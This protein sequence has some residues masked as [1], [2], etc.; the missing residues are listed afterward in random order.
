MNQ[1]TLYILAAFFTAVSSSAHGELPKEKWEGYKPVAETD[2]HE[3]LKRFAEESAFYMQSVGAINDPR[4]EDLSEQIKIVDS[5]KPDL[6]AISNFDPKIVKFQLE[7]CRKQALSKCPIS[8]YSSQGTA[9]F[10]NGALSTCRHGMHNWIVLAAQENNM[11]V[12]EISPPIILKSA[13]EAGKL[14]TI[15]NS[16]L[17]G[18]E[19]FAFQLINKDERLNFMHHD[20]EYPSFLH[21]VAFANADYV[22]LK[23]AT[24]NE[25][26]HDEN[27]DVLQSRALPKDLVGTEVF[28]I[29]YP[30]KISGLPGN[31][32][33]A[34]G[35]TI[36]AT[37]GYV[38]DNNVLPILQIVASNF[39]TGGMSGGPV[40]TADGKIIGVQCSSVGEAEAGTNPQN[41]NS[42][43]LPI[44][45]A[46][47]EEIWSAMT[48]P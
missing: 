30:M 14:V 13:N 28:S 36:M 4:K 9:F 32:Q 22:E 48:Y 27:I 19:L 16:S 44:G 31:I 8:R 47:I 21:S 17:E 37:H 26:F 18:F 33:G 39:G 38:L 2:L 41:A 24:G 29:G 10:N 35:K 23:L 12:E 1:L 5:S 20:S 7:T 43:F 45:R 42:A 46:A 15:Y 6:N 3:N 34:P 40:I 25:S 11:K